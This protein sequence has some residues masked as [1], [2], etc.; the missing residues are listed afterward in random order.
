MGCLCLEEVFFFLIFGCV[1]ETFCDQIYSTLFCVLFSLR[2]GC[3]LGGYVNFNDLIVNV[4][5][6]IFVASSQFA[7]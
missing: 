1:S 5:I 3:S 6:S 4:S 7:K 2:L